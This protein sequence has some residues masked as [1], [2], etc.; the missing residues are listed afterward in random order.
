MNE[1]MGAATDGE[2]LSVALDALASM[3]CAFMAPRPWPP[4]KE[5]CGKCSDRGVPGVHF[6]IAKRRLC[7]ERIIRELADEATCR[8][9][10]EKGKRNDGVGGRL[11]SGSGCGTGSL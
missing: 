8:E 10:L 4:T 7:W 1:H 6:T 5:W 2:M 3:G 11:R 9:A